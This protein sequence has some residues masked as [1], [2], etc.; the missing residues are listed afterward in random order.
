MQS[1][2]S[3]IPLDIT[4]NSWVR[5]GAGTFIGSNSSVQQ[6]ININISERCLNGM[7]ATQVLAD[8]GTEVCMPLE[9]T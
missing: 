5:I 7:G 1:S 2:A 3:G 8:C 6:Y 4:F 9:I